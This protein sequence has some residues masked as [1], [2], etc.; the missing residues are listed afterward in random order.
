[1]TGEEVTYAYDG[2]QRLISAVTTD[3]AGGQSFSYDGFGNRT[4][5]TVTK[6][7][8]PSSSFTIDAATNRIINAGFGYDA[9]GNMTAGGGTA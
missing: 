2:L 8:G 5:A 4:G 1:M 7:S 3:P 6:G 9:N